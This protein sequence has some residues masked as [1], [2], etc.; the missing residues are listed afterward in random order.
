MWASQRL[1]GTVATNE[2]GE[3]D[4]SAVDAMGSTNK[5]MM[6]TMPLV[7]LYIGYQ[8]PAAISIYWL[9]QAVFGGSRNLC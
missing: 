6:L 7:S 5:V 8:M 3:K 2:K 9:A 4:T 1:N